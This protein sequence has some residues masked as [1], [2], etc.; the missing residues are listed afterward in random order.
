MTVHPETAGG[1]E[2]DAQW[3]TRIDGSVIKFWG[4]KSDAKDAARAIGWP[5]V[6]VWPVWTRFQRGYAIKQVHEGF[7]T[8]GGYEALLADSNRR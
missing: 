8:H 4:R 2:Y 7:L 5:L 3:G 6:S 1:F